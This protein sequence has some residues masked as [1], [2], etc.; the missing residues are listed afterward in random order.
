MLGGSYVNKLV[1]IGF[2]VVLIAGCSKARQPGYPFEHG[3]FS[4]AEA[5][6]IGASGSVYRAVWNIGSV[7]HVCLTPGVLGGFNAYYNVA[8]FLPDGA[9]TE[10]TTVDAPEGYEP[11]RLLQLFY[12]MVVWFRDPSGK[13]EDFFKEAIP[14]EEYQRRLRAGEDKLKEELERL[15]A[16]GSDTQVIAA[17]RERL[18]QIQDTRNRE[19]NR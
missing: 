18:K 4:A 14:V 12:P 13:R 9:L 3:T 8:V 5:A 2:F 16:S 7:R 1:L 15:E 10:R 11:H 6:S 17:L 19:S